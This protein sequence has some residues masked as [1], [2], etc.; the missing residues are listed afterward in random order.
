MQLYS[1]QHS[2]P[3]KSGYRTLVDLLLFRAFE[4]P[5][6]IGYIFLVDGENLEI[7][8]TFRDLDQ[9]AKSIAFD[10]AQK[11]VK[12]KDKILLGY[13]SGLDFIEA[14]FGCLYAGAI[15][16][17]VPLP[18]LNSQDSRFTYILKDSEAQ[19]CLTHSHQLR[20]F[21]K[22]F[23][24][25][26]PSFFVN[27][28]DQILLSNV[29]WD[30]PITSSDDIAF[31]Q[32]TSG[33]T[34]EPKGVLISHKNILSNQAMIQDATGLNKNVVCVGWAPLFHDLGLICNILFPLYVGGKSVLMSPTSFLQ[35]PVRWLSA[36]SRYRA[37]LSG[38]P[39]FAYDLC[40]QKITSE[41]RSM[42][43]LSSWEIAFNGSEPVQAKTLFNFSQHFES[44]GF[45]KEAFFPTFGMAEATLFV[46][47]KKGFSD[48]S[49]IYVDKHGLNEG[50]ISFEQK[51]SKNSHALV[52]C[53]KTWGDQN[54]KIVDPHS[55]SEL[56]GGS[57]GEICICGSNI[58]LGYLNKSQETQKAFGLTIA[59][60][61]Q[62]FFKTGDLGFLTQDG[63]LVVVGRSKDLII[64]RGK[65]FYPQDIELSVSSSHEAIQSNA[66]AA[67]CVFEESQERLVIVAELKREFLKQK[68]DAQILKTIIEKISSEYGLETAYIFL[69]APFSIPRTSSGKIQRQKCKQLFLENSL[70]V[71]NSWG[72]ASSDHPV[73]NAAE[74][75]ALTNDTS[76]MLLFLFQKVVKIKAQDLNSTFNQLGGDSIQ[77]IEFTAIYA[78]L[79]KIDLSL[80]EVHIH[81]FRELVRI[82]ED[83]QFLEIRGITLEQFNKVCLELG[84]LPAEL[85][86]KPI[87][88]ESKFLSLSVKFRKQILE[89]VKHLKEEKKLVYSA[90]ELMFRAVKKE[91]A[92]EILENHFLQLEKKP[93]M[94]SF[95][96]GKLPKIDSIGI[97]YFP[98]SIRTMSRDGENLLSTWTQGSPLIMS[99][100]E[101]SLGNAALIALPLYEESLYTEKDRLK[102][103]LN[104]GLEM[105]NTLQASTVS[106]MG[107]VPSA[108]EYGKIVEGLSR[109]SFPNLT[110]TTGHE[111]TVASVSLA[112]E[113]ILTQTGR[114]FGEEVVGVLGLGSIGKASIELLILLSLHPKEIIL[115]DLFSNQAKL[116]S[117]CHQLKQIG[118]KG[119]ITLVLTDKDVPKAF[120]R[121][122]FIIGA[123]NAAN[124]LMPE[125]FE[126]GT[127]VVDDS[128]PHCFDSKKAFSRLRGKKDILFTEAGMLKLPFPIREIRYCPEGFYPFLSSFPGIYQ[129]RKSHDIPS[130]LLSGLLLKQY[131]EISPT[132]GLPKAANA[133]KHHSLLS[134]L[135]I[136]APPLSFNGEVLPIDLHEAVFTSR[137][138]ENFKNPSRASIQTVISST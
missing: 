12:P 124:I 136:T 25:Q 33:S 137:F 126:P 89:K 85:S 107:L 122:S 68:Q 19:G 15:P 40:T 79:F 54:I 29:S 43:D 128:S 125:M 22:V 104:N 118:F 24:V 103:A 63:D 81:T 37:S 48:S 49:I 45:K 93:L 84:G 112:V 129:N 16:V 51:A 132:I 11:G 67:F 77:A 113:K 87:T 135:N 70:H 109:S 7:S 10:L 62:R 44:C 121:S 34:S 47:G 96:E 130:C 88:V 102:V 75:A 82:T 86:P 120:Y 106:L 100:Y 30:P 46:T 134:K 1:Y 38:A 8:L 4:T 65:N 6:D 94:T 69:I 123:T 97:A 101:T 73:M 36:I 5:L 91:A 59:T 56:T 21:E 80:E 66:I 60:D 127:L 74:K 2:P 99:I 108:T 26:S 13:P 17:P 61:P 105:A 41:Q 27:P 76:E 18:K 32:Y 111:S 110:V 95:N 31:I 138:R 133:R 23:T 39:N 72:K 83:R 58:S 28:T 64:I 53:G 131:P 20:H 92:A 116:E 9:R 3:N 42:L 55:C 14:F 115:C 78:D 71:L 117:I 50:E 90:N 35:K 114:I 98:S 119:K 57:I 52:N